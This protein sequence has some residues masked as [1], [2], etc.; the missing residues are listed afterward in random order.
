M[1]ESPVQP[2]PQTPVLET[3]IAAVVLIAN[4]ILPGSGTLTAGIIGQQR[5][6]GRAIAQFFLTLVIVGY[7]W[8][9]ITGIQALTNASWGSKNKTA[10]ATETEA[11]APAKAKATPAPKKA[12]SKSAKPKSKAKA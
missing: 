3:P 4:L 2:Y 8:G 11:P 6:I 10:S 12:P 9:I 7:V 5:L 1:A